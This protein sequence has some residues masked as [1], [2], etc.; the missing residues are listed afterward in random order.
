[1]K[2]FEGTVPGRWDPCS[3]DCN[4]AEAHE[5][6][7]MMRNGMPRECCGMARYG[8]VS[9]SPEDR[10]LSDPETDKSD[11]RNA[12]LAL[13]DAHQLWK[14]LKPRAPVGRAE[15]HVMSHRSVQCYLIPRRTV[16]C[17]RVVLQGSML[18]T[19]SILPC[20]R[21]K[22]GGVAKGDFSCGR[23]ALPHEDPLETTGRA[24]SH[25]N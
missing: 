20:A 12:R 6:R 7:R 18:V 15:Q 3:Y 4:M 1:M 19:A 11:C 10:D 23:A 8:R 13:W 2:V 24:S 14:R 22:L 21:A 16:P 9:P 25:L 5:S 17:H